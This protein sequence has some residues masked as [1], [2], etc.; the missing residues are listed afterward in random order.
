VILDS[1]VFDVGT[2]G[3]GE[4]IDVA[5]EIAV[6]LLLVVGC[7]LRITCCVKRPFIDTCGA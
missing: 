6:L 1:V 4:I 3:V 7:L 5:A 2:A